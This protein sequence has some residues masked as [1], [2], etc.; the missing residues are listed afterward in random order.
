MQNA[1]PAVDTSSLQLTL[2]GSSRSCAGSCRPSMVVE[3]TAGYPLMGRPFGDRGFRDSRR[4][5]RGDTT[6]AEGEAGL[7]QVQ[8]A[9]RLRISRSTLNR[10]EAAS[11]NTTLRT[12]DHLCRA[13]KW[14]PSDL[15]GQRRDRKGNRQVRL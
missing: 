6:E 11:Q 5:A 10:L 12:L 15:F 13:L 1:I 7:S 4:T 9:R 14:E 3:S 2:A 8:M